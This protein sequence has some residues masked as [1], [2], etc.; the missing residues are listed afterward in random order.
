VEAM[1]N[2]FPVAAVNPQATGQTGFAATENEAQMFVDIFNNFLQSTSD[3]TLTAPGA[4]SNSLM[5]QLLNS[6]QASKTSNG[7]SLSDSLDAIGIAFQQ[8]SPLNSKGQLTLDTDKL[9]SAFSANQ[10]A[11]LAVVS[12]AMQSIGQLAA[13]S[14]S[15]LAPDF[16]TSSTSNNLF[17]QGGQSSPGDFLS[18][19]NSSSDTP[20]IWDTLALSPQLEAAQ[21]LGSFKTGNTGG[22]SPSFADL[23]AQGGQTGF[24]FLNAFNSNSGDTPSIWDTLALSPQL[25][26]AQVLGTLPALPSTAAAATANAQPTPQ[27]TA[28]AIAAYLK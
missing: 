2:M 24:D 7:L 6:Q 27:A 13:K 15:F 11:T 23:F 5:V 12:Q 19:F 1:M 28:K 3:T 9:Q 26:A 8:P 14:S 10:S 4:S 18:S 17:S 21:I 25:V 20:S 22:A 16:G